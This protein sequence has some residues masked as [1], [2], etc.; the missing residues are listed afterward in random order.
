MKII[1]GLSRS[2]KFVHPVVALGVFDGLHRGH[3]NILKSA[4]TKAKQIKGTSVAVTFFPHPQ[5]KLSLY[6]LAHRLKLIAQLGVDVCIVMKFSRSFAKI[7]AEDFVAK[8]L[9]KKINAQ[10]VYVGQNF[11]FGHRALG[12]C[13][14]LRQTAKRYGF[15]IKIFK[16]LKSGA[17]IIS[18]TA[19][20]ALI[21]ESKI[22][23]AQKLLGRRV[24]ILGTVI[25][26]RSIGRGMGYPTANINAHHE[27]VPA[28]GIYAVKIF[29]G[30]KEY[31]GACY[32]GTRPTLKLKNKIKHIEVHI[33]NFHRNIYGAVLEIQ[34]IKLIRSDQKFASL[35]DLSAQIKKDL[36]V[37]RKIL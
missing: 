7:S 25:H 16:V 17:L 14:L 1:Y 5:R 13:T 4:V 15:K 24:S 29:L 36:Y 18:S 8:L 2:I 35:D 10:F 12:N 20:R 19:V 28:A 31:S 30:Q 37:C 33:F 9:V 34:F 6:S 22:K 27:V 21:K 23:A 3:R 26:G 11:H 32:I